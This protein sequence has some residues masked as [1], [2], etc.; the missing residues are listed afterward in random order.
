MAVWGQL[1]KFVTS[2][3]TKS[4]ERRESWES[5]ITFGLCFNYVKAYVYIYVFLNLF[6]YS[7][8][9]TA[10]GKDTEWCNT[11]KYVWGGTIHTQYLRWCLKYHGYIKMWSTFNLHTITNNE[12]GYWSWEGVWNAGGLERSGECWKL[13]KYNIIYEI[14]KKLKI[15]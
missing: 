5:G 12:K 13:F 11:W 10:T 2:C 7:I 14:L 6:R 3:W 8:F 1:K 15:H 4:R 9:I